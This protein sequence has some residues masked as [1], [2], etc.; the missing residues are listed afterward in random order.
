VTGDFDDVIGGVRVRLREIGDDYFVDAL[1]RGRLDQFTKVGAV[2]LEFA[3]MGQSQ[4]RVS[5][6]R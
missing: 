4:Q 1:S 5:D 3:G 2:G 6:A